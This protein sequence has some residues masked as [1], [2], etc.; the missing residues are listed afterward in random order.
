MV[1]AVLTV[2]LLLLCFSR[3]QGEVVTKSV[4]YAHGDQKLEGYL[5]YDDSVQG[6]R[7][8]VVIVHEWWGLNDCVR[9]RAE[10]LAKLGYV[11]FAIDMYGKVTKHPDQSAEWMNRIRQDLPL[12]RG[13]ARAGLEILKQDTR[14]NPERMAAIL[15]PDFRQGLS[16]V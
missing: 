15:Q 4:P 8:G 13:R 3:A 14:V 9:R 16:N 10:Q 11:A 6:K 2:C 5:A 7:P 12:W 1:K